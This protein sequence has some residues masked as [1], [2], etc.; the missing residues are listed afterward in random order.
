MNP[1][2]N[3]IWSLEKELINV[4]PWKVSIKISNLYVNRLKA[5]N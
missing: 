4:K 1:V 3:Q 5:T 2:Q